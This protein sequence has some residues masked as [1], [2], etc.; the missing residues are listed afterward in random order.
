MAQDVISE[1]G[2]GAKRAL[3]GCPVFHFD[4]L[5][6][7]AIRDPY[8]AL[9]EARRQ[10]PVFYM[11]EYDQ[12]CVTRHED[13]LDVYRDPI[14]Y[15]NG[16]NWHLRVKRPEALA[17]EIPDEWEPPINK[18]ALNGTD[19]PQHTRIRKLMQYAFTPKRVKEREGP[20]REV[21]DDLLSAFEQDGAAEFVSQFASPLPV[22]VV[23]G[24]VG[25][26]P[27]RSHMW[28][29]WAEDWF[30]LTGAIDL[31][32]EEAIERWRRLYS[33]DLY[34][35]KFVEDRVREPQ[36]D[37]TSDLAVARSEDGSTFTVEE[38]IGNVMGV[39]LAGA[40]TTTVL[41]SNMVH[42]LL[43]DRDRWEEIK[44]DRTLIPRA[45]EET[46]RFRSPVRGVNRVTTADV[47]L[48]GVPIPKGSRLYIHLGSA[49]R[50]DS[51]FES[52]DSFDLHRTNSAKHLGFGIWAHFCI[53]APL[54]RLEVQIALERLVSRLPDLRLAEGQ[55]PLEYT[56]N[57]ILPTVTRL[58]LVW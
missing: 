20:I 13:L 32:E 52:P 46:M 1:S 57:M 7:E 17:D 30:I 49:G 35:R 40:D 2:Q 25:M 43:S 19:P 21:A 31:P 14:T 10:A 56:V 8:P 5:T 47:V 11:P 39:V 29:Q 22:T 51:L 36:D 18:F 12:W 27:D 16:G 54:A 15:S 38:L 41:L 23:S 53:G 50:D 9:A 44:A 24:M 3:E 45:V 4:P 33:F 42:T 48:G 58:D 34:L 6:P 37:L 26:P 28:R 55:G